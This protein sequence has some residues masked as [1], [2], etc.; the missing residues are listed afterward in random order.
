M[1]ETYILRC[2]DLH[3]ALERGLDGMDFSKWKCKKQNY[4]RELHKFKRTKI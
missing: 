3:L 2:E 4:T 1:D